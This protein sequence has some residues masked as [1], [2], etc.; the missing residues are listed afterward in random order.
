MSFTHVTETAFQKTQLGVETSWG[1]GVPATIQLG[2]LMLTPQIRRIENV[3]TPRGIMLPGIQSIG[4]EY[5]ELALEGQA[6]FEDLA[7]FLADFVSDSQTDPLSYTIESGGLQVPGAVVTA[8]A[9]DADRDKINVTGNMLGKK[10]VVQAASGGLSPLTQTPILASPVAITFDSVTVENI[11]GWNFSLADM[12]GIAHY[13][14]DSEP[15]AIMQKAAKGTFGVLLEADD[16]NM[17]YLAETGTIAVE[18]SSANGANSLTLAFDAKLGE[19]DRYS[20]QEGIWAI[21]LN[22]TI[23][24]KATKAVDITFV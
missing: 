13:V 1:T 20:D 7:Y 16:T 14:G 12:W 2:S 4:R 17:A 6:S 18:I 24:N 15:G 5:T 8:I 11:F 23:M 22:M 21:K 19:P 9:L 3:F 10:G